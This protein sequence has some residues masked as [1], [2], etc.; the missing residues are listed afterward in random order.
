MKF[1]D[2]FSKGEK[3]L[4]KIKSKTKDFI[5]NYSYLK[6]PFLIFCIIYG[7][8]FLTIF[9]ANFYYIDD[10]GRAYSGYQDWGYFSR[11]VSNGLSSIFHTSSYL[12]DISPLT[13]IIA[14][15]FLSLSSCIIIDLFSKEKKVTFWKIAAVLPIGVV[16]YFLECISYK[17]D[18]PYMALSILAVIFPF[19]FLKHSWKS[20]ALASFIGALIMCMTYQASSGI[21]LVLV[22]MISFMWYRDNVKIKKI[23]KFIG[24]S[25]LSY[26][27]GMVIFK[28]FIMSPAS[29]YASNSMLPISSIISGSFSNLKSFYINLTNDFRNIWLLI[30]A[31]ITIGF[32]CLST[33]RSK[34]KKIPTFVLSIIV[35]GLSY[36]AIFGFYIFLEKPLLSPRAMCAFGTLIAILAIQCC[37]LD[38][39]VITKLA[40]TILS[41]CFISFAFTYGNALNE[42]KHYTDFR[43]Q[44]LISDLNSVNATT[45]ERKT[46]KI[47]GSIGNA[48]VIEQMPE[49]YKLIDKLVPDMLI[50]S[51]WYWGSYYLMHYFNLQKAFDYKEDVDMQNMDLPILKDN[52]YHT[53]R[54]NDK[55]IFVELKE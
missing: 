36:L 49:N 34:Q 28:L 2:I 26:L 53:I 33:I 1:K 43:I 11:H 32:I 12:T 3:V 38:K 5:S 45:G 47:S 21:Y 23:A 20:F 39:T 18:S 50:G 6:M 17:Y 15:L 55:Y 44:T 16:P 13:Q 48:P 22:L 31:I 46:L 25:A 19:I 7:I 27:L 40:C 41:F 51:G 37:N 30:I 35:V 54:G 10:L 42:Q 8:A 52:I 4:K 14:I 24:I 29:S 9:R